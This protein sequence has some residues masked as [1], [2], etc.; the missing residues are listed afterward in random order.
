MLINR[1]FCYSNR[2]AGK[3]G[4]LTCFIVIAMFLFSGTDLLYAQWSGNP[5]SNRKLIEKTGNPVNLSVINDGSKG[6]YIIWQ[7]KIGN[8]TDL[9]FQHLNYDGNPSFFGEGVRINN[10][11][12]L[13]EPAKG[14]TGQNNTLIL[15]WKETVSEK[16]TV[17]TVQRVKSNGYRFWGDGGL[18]INEHEEQITSFSVISDSQGNSLFSF[19]ER[20]KDANA[21]YAIKLQKVSLNGYPEY[22]EDGVDV[23]LS[24]NVI[25][26]LQMIAAPDGGS[27]IFWLESQNKINVLNAKYV[28][29]R[30]RMKW[31][32]TGKDLFRQNNSILNYEVTEVPGKGFHLTWT[33]INS[34]KNIYHQLF[35]YNGSNIWDDVYKNISDPE[36]NLSGPQV[37]LTSDNGLV[38]GWVTENKNMRSIKLMKYNLNGAQLWKETRSPNRNS[39]TRN[40]FGISLIPDERGGVIVAWF[41]KAKGENRPSVYAQRIGLKSELLWGDEGIPVARNQKTDKSYLNILPDGYNGIIAVFKESEADKHGIFGQRVFANKTYNSQISEFHVTS[42]NDTVSVAWAVINESGVLGYRVERT[43][44]R[45]KDDESDWVE[46][47]NVKPKNLNITGRYSIKDFPSEQGMYFYRVVQIGS[48]GDLNVSNTGRIDYFPERNDKIFIIPGQ[49][50]VFG[51]SSVIAFNLPEPVDVRIELFNSRLEKLEEYK[52]DETV[53][54]INRFSFFSRNFPQGVYYY[55]FRAGEYVDVKKLIITREG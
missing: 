44:I 35:D 15:A 14:I 31:L 48:F 52:L 50:V 51:D 16:H 13:N 18:A 4:V 54:G 11:A 26:E 24:K 47:A 43:I 12:A 7:E 27:I 34:K 23:I 6:F 42:L 41:S 49:Q 33:T 40:D 55:R 1:L 25:T 21:V 37:C 39:N 22:P 38:F 32:K 19:I 46:I 3:P 20:R 10:R 17:L 2:H 5:E 36:S 53:K 30:G 8:Y 45:E 29:K 28:D 9:F